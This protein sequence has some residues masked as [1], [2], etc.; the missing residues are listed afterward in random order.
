MLA[1]I[2]RRRQQISSCSQ[3]KRRIL[4]LRTW[5]TQLRSTAIVTSRTKPR[6]FSSSSKPSKSVSD[7]VGNLSWI[8]AASTGIFAGVVSALTGVGGGI[9]IIPVRA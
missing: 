3:F 8:V 9:I 1:L 7:A 6:V 5:E 4:T 2:S